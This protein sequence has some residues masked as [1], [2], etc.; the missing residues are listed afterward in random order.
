MRDRG[1]D[2]PRRKHPMPR[3][4]PFAPFARR[5]RLRP[6]SQSRND[7]I[8][9]FSNPVNAARLREAMED[10]LAGRNMIPFTVEQ[11]RRDLGLADE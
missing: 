8:Y 6:R 5:V 11:L 10:S 4:R 1:G 3:T 9:L 2:H 7:H